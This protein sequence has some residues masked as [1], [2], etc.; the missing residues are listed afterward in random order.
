M[1]VA[2]VGPPALTRINARRGLLSASAKR[3]HGLEAVDVHVAGMLSHEGLRDCP[4]AVEDGHL[5]ALVCDVQSEIAYHRRQAD[6]A[7][8]AAAP[9]FPVPSLLS[10]RHGLRHRILEALICA[11]HYGTHLS[12]RRERLDGHLIGL[13]QGAAELIEQILE[14]HG[15]RDDSNALLWTAAKPLQEDH[16][17]GANSLHIFFQNVEKPRPSRS[18]QD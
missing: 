1:I 9:H 16:C 13:G 8:V 2:S 15:M 14:E 12:V 7:H 17:P 10:R 6:D 3:L 4:S 5:E 18:G 11:Q